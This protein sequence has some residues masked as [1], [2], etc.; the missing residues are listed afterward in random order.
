MTMSEARRRA[1][2]VYLKKPYDSLCFMLIELCLILAC[3]T[4]L[5]F[6]TTGN[7]KAL[8]LLAIPFYLLL[9]LWARYNA[10]IVMQGA[11]TGGSLLN[12]G[13][14]DPENY[15]AKLLFGLK[16]G[17]FLLLWGAP[18]IAAAIFARGQI[19]GDT[20]AFTVLRSIKAF[21]GGTLVRGGIYL[22]II[23]VVLLLLFCVGLGWHCGDRHAACLG[24]RTLIKGKHWKMVGC[25]FRSLSTI[26]PIVAAV[27]ILIVRYIPVLL[28]LDMLLTK[29]ARLPDTRTSIVIVAIGAALT[30][31][32]MPLR[33]L[34]IAA[35]V[36]GMKE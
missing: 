19:S 23:A 6:L 9:M 28:D 10:A 21:G 30:V 18:L 27:V 16:Q 13:L 24:D 2:R 8:A 4:P 1:V 11:L 14:V 17:C 29:D 33:S 22:A 35:Y 36:R 20:D 12:P 32:L 7:L 26:L 15:G 34:M 3:L 5:L 31:P 25:W